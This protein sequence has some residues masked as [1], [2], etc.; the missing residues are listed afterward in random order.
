MKRWAALLFLSLLVVVTVIVTQQARSEHE[1]K[2]REAQFQSILRRYSEALK[3]GMTRK[4]VEAYLAAHQ[5]KFSR[6]PVDDPNAYADITR[7]G[8]GDG[9]WY[10]SREDIYLAFQFIA[11][12]MRS[13]LP[14]ALPSDTLKKITLYPKLEDCL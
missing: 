8:E 2:E 1:K 13:G 5:A 7:I 3:P 12:P 14:S 10:C 6:F 9:H 11:D 4:D